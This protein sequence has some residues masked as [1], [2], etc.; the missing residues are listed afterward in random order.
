MRPMYA[1]D[2]RYDK[3]L[4]LN[5]VVFTTNDV[6]TL[7]STNNGSFAA[8]CS[9]D[10]SKPPAFYDTFALRDSEGGNKLKKTW[11]FFRSRRSRR[12]LK[13]HQAVPV[14][15]CWNGIVAMDAAP[16]Y[17]QARPLSFRGIPEDL[18]RMHLEASECCLIH[19]DNPLSASKGVWVNPRV[20]VGYSG[21]AYEAVNPPHGQPWLSSWAIIY[22]SWQNRLLRWFTS[23]SFK[24]RVVAQRLAAWQKQSPENVEHGAFCLVDEMQVLV[25]NGWAHV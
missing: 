16:F 15:S 22:G 6:A 17:N 18:A 23:P 4:L 12:A 10:F 1:S 3:V 9:L 5:D 24:D 25:G 21:A 8:A 2:V 20:R 14:S 13:A 19:A 7:M 11:P